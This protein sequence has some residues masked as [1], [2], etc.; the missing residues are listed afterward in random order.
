MF[1][2]AGVGGCFCIAYHGHECPRKSR[3]RA[4]G[5]C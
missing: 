3:T 1:N 5:K 4:N 2:P